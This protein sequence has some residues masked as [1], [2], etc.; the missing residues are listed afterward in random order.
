MKKNFFYFLIFLM[1]F[2][3]FGCAAPKKM[4]HWGDYSS[5]LY[6]CR[7][8][9][10]EENFLKHKQ[11]LEKIVE[12]SRKEDVKVPPGVYAEL[13]YF[14][15]R[16]SK[17]DDAIKYFEL[18]KQIYPESEIF[19]QRLTQAARDRNKDI[20]KKTDPPKKD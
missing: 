8:D 7:K 1:S 15:F 19:M 6:R 10:T 4:Y 5:S 17:Y 18:E 20:E 11:V 13:G 9:A 12:E 14:Y 2:L 16:Q 3:F